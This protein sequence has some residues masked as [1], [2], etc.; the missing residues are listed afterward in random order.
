MS[1]HGGDQF[2]GADSESECYQACIPAVAMI[3]LGLQIDLSNNVD[4]IILK[5]RLN[6]QNG[7]LYLQIQSGNL[8]VVLTRS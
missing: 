2:F 8:V 6:M 4:A 5:H 7:D 1:V 3:F